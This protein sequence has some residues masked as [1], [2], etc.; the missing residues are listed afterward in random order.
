[1]TFKKLLILAC[2]ATAQWALAQG[3]A[4]PL[5]VSVQLAPLSLGSQV[6]TG[7]NLGVSD[8]DL[9][10]GL[11]RLQTPAYGA[12]RFSGSGLSERALSDN[13]RGGLFGSVG[14]SW[15]YSANSS[16]GVNYRIDAPALPDS[17]AQRSMGLDYGYQFIWGLSLHTSQDH[18]LNDAASRWGGGLSI[19]FSR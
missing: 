14:A 7:L 9:N 4:N 16:L 15:R 19:R 3:P 1:M 5:P 6:G 18:G 8:W 10:L 12:V 2:A 13:Q 11:P 17:A